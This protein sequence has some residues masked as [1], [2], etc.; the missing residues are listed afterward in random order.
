MKDFCKPGIRANILQFYFL[1]ALSSTTSADGSG[2]DKVYDPYVQPQER[3]LEWRSRYQDDKDNQRL[4]NRTHKLGLGASL[5]ER[6]FAEVYFIAESSSGESTALEASEIELKWQL[7]EQGEYLADWGLLFEL[8]KELNEKVWEFKTGLI[9]SR[10]WNDWVA[11][12][13]LF[14]IYEWGD[15]IEDELET[16]AAL[17]ARYRFSQQLEPALE[18]FISED[19]RAI[20]PALSGTVLFANNNS[21]YW[22]TGYYVD[23][24]TSGEDTLRFALEYEF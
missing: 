12:A 9:S 8:E 2:I 22:Q 1:L 7:T 10:Q 13:N 11:T 15:D 23:L 21:V 16:A 24:R 20:G 17:Q 19:T 3:E 18:L 14:V 4:S 6:R 5:D